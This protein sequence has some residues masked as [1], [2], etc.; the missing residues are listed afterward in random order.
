MTAH[1]A[2]AL[3]LTLLLAARCGGGSSDN[4]TSSAGPDDAQKVGLRHFTGQATVQGGYQ[5][6]EAFQFTG[7]QGLGDEVCTILYTMQAV[8]ERMDCPDC[9]WAFDLE[10]TDASIHEESSKG[11]ADL[12]VTPAEFEGLRASY[13]Y[14]PS[15]GAYQDVLMYQIGAYGWYPVSF[16]SWDD[17]LFQYDWELGLYY[18]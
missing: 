16:A 1:T 18:Y 5:G 14:A 9:L 17:P 4:D 2:A 11:C 13:G 8:G 10:G 7:A 3:G 12:G 6:W 15:S